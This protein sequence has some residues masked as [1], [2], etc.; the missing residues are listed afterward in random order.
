[1][2]DIFSY[3][4]W[5]IQLNFFN[6]VFKFVFCLF[7]LCIKI[8]SL[9]YHNFDG[10][11]LYIYIY[12]YKICIIKMHMPFVYSLGWTISRRAE[13]FSPIQVK[14]CKSSS[15]S[16]GINTT[17]CHFNCFGHQ[18]PKSQR[19]LHQQMQGFDIENQKYI[20]IVIIVNKT[21]M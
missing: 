8:N 2:T 17:W 20:S 11:S 21:F 1:M 4:K 19:C 16:N 6:T 7:K 15:M 18:S 13:L 12:I 3:I 5:K 9:F 10:L 14:L